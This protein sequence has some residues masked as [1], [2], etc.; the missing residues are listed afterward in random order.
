M[1]VFKNNTENYLLNQLIKVLSVL[2]LYWLRNTYKMN[3]KVYMAQNI[4]VL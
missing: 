4:Q 3:K 2:R 1:K